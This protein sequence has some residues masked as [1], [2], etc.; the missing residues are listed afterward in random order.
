MV[1]TLLKLLLHSLP[2]TIIST[3]TSAFYITAFSSLHCFLWK[4]K[5]KGDASMNLS[6]YHSNKNVI[7]PWLLQILPILSPTFSIHI[8][9]SLQ[10]YLFFIFTLLLATIFSS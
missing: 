9:P 4:E 10:H 6:I 7:V 8:H 2:Y 5:R 1:T 3:G